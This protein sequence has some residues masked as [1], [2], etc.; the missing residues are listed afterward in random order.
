MNIKYFFL[1]DVKDSQLNN[2]YILKLHEILKN[3][4]KVIINIINYKS[5]LMS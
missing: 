1:I 5:F 4:N 2:Q 3:G